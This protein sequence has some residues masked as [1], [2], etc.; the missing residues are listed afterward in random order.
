MDKII[1]ADTRERSPASNTVDGIYMALDIVEAE[2][3][4]NVAWSTP[5]EAMSREMAFEAQRKGDYRLLRERLQYAILHKMARCTVHSA[6]WMARVWVAR[7]ARRRERAREEE[8]E[9]EE[10]EA[11]PLD[12]F[13]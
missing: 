13:D 3:M 7:L 5:G 8:E 11:I 9:E 10:E 2:C 4:A 12:L 1:A 6:L